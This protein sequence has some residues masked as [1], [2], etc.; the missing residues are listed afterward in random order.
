MSLRIV[1]GAF[2]GRI[3]KS[4]KSDNT[5]P[6]TSMLREAVFNIC[7]QQIEGARFLDLFAGSGAMGFEALSR[8]ANFATF[9]ER[10][11][12]AAQCIKENAAL[13]GV[14]AK[15]QLFKAPVLKVLPRLEGP[16]D[17][18]YIDP[19]YAQETLHILAAI[20][21]HRLLA[22]EGT[23]FL[24]ERYEGQA[25]FT[26]TPFQLINSRRYSNT[27]LHQFKAGS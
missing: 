8:G 26:H 24:E 5:R 27:H 6:T 22:P 4:P 19:P 10:D 21:Q 16:Y 25:D 15:V 9:I 7:S 3:L 11:S 23:L 18:I 13:L 12:H 2:R 1:G 14:E 20:H 17:L